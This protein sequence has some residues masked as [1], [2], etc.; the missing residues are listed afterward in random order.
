METKI[1]KSD[2]LFLCL[3]LLLGILAE[4]SFFRGQIGIS[5]IVFVMVFLFGILLAI[6]PLLLFSS[7]LW[8]S[9]TLL[10]LALDSKLFFK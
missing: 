9:C 8:V 3:C 2:W 6:P 10:Y 5:Y 1:G 7:T 4:E